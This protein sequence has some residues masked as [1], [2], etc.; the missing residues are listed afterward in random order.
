MTAS[1]ERAAP[2]AAWA[3]RFAE[4]S[5][6]PDRFAIRE[7]ALPAQI[8]VRGDASDPAF[9]AKA[10]D[11]FGCEFPVKP[12][13]WGGTAESGVLWLGPD[14]WLAFAPAGG[15]DALAAKLRG[16]LSG[17]HHSVV[18][19]SANRTIIEIGG[20]DARIVLAKG[21]PLDLHRAAFGPGQCAQS[22]IAKSQAILQCIGPDT[23][24]VFVRI[25]FASYLSEW[26]LDAAAE[27]RASREHGMLGLTL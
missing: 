18:D 11:A 13:T 3:G 21:C 5:G 14:E 20:S 19:L 16:A 24:R 6:A 12:N 23:F 27:L 10:R 17:L 1:T 7:L 8:N 15:N 26:L 2:L 22:V 9:L 25:S 4:A